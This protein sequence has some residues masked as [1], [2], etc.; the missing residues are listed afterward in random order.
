MSVGSKSEAKLA[1]FEAK[2]FKVVSQKLP[3]N[4]VE[5]YFTDLFSRVAWDSECPGLEGWGALVRFLL[6]KT[7]R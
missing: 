5:D 3:K 1:S 6:V 2:N 7:N 4:K